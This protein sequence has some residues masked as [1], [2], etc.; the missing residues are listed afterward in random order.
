MVT[1]VASNHTPK[2]HLAFVGHQQYDMHLFCNNGLM[3][4]MK[5]M[6]KNE[7]EV[8]EKTK[9]R[10]YE[11]TRE[12]NERPPRRCSSS[13]SSGCRVVSARCS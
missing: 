1:Q 10:K 6:K 11:K 2:P 8:S 4:K 13:T 7:Y 5:K 9:V 12:R 3:K